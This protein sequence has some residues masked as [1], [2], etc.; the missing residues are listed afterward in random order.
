MDRRLR[1]LFSRALLAGAAAATLLLSGCASIGLENAQESSNA[2]ES[3]ARVAA[4][5]TA[6]EST[7]SVP[8]PTVAPDTAAVAAPE[9]T[10]T[11]TESALPRIVPRLE[12]APERLLDQ[13]LRVRFSPEALKAGAP[14]DV[15][16]LRAMV[17]LDTTRL[18]A[19]VTAMGLT[20]W[21]VDFTKE[22]LT[23]TRHALLDDHLDAPKFVRDFALAYWPVESLRATLPERC[24]LDADFRQSA[25]GTDETRTLVC[26]GAALLRIVTTTNA[27]PNAAGLVPEG[28]LSRT[29]I[30]N[31]AEGYRIEIESREN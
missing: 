14:S 21:R 18:S 6:P 1:R 15:P 24:R 20:V 5:V 9:S 16:T 30:D 13:Q 7:L 2:D 8:S 22:G 26:G 23:E 12:D 25:A 4:P 3:T 27:A 29:S 31:R 10:A 17:L 28:T 19:V 11:A